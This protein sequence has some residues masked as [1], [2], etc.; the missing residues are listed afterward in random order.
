[1]LFD[2][3]KM[4]EIQLRYYQT[5]QFRFIIT[6]KSDGWIKGHFDWNNETLNKILELDKRIEAECEFWYLDNNGFRLDDNDLF[7][8][9]PWEIIESNGLNIKVVQRF[10]DYKNGEA[11]FVSEPWFRIGDEYN[12]TTQH[13]V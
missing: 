13:A 6:E 10:M 7:V 3:E 1:M 9:S 11:S 2:K 5:Y 12:N 8:K 4:I